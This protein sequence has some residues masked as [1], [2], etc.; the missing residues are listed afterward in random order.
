MTVRLGVIGLGNIARQHIQNVQ[1][2]AVTDCV[3][4]AVCSRTLPDDLPEGATHFSDYEAMIS[5]GQCD[6]VLVA[7][8]TLYHKEMGLAVLKAGLH[9]LMEKPLA[10]SNAEA[11]MLIAAKQPGQIFALMLNQRCAPVFKKMKALIESD[12]LGEIKRTHWTMTNWFRPEVYFSVSDWRAT[13]KGEGGGLLVNQCIHNLDIFQWLCGLPETV[14]GFCSM[15]KYHSIEVED[16]ATAYFNYANG[17]SGTFVGSTGESPGFNRLEIVG[18]KASLTYDGKR[19]HLHKNTPATS[20][21]CRETRDMF[22][23]PGVIVLDITPDDTPVN[24][25]ADILNNFVSAIKRDE[26]L[27]APAEEGL[28]SLGLANAILMSHWQ[29]ESVAC[30]P[31]SAAYQNLLDA[32]ISGSSLRKK[33]DIQVKIDMD[34]SYR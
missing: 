14:R 27:I 22:G 16:E 6:A 30:P 12:E 1:C 21:F 34:K 23:Q 17:A 13:W 24:Q 8:P 3:V 11:E 33:Q 28:K 15:G 20:A 2:G 25:H 29:G 4:S 5:S 32:K 26:P 31:D 7:S 19:L 10:L 18:D 9:L